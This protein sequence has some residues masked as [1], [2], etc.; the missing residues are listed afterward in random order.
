MAIDGVTMGPLP[1]SVEGYD[2]EVI[3][4]PHIYSAGE[5]VLTEARLMINGREFVYSQLV[6]PGEFS[7]DEF[8]EFM[9]DPDC[10]AR[11]WMAYA[12]RRERDWDYEN[13]RPGRTGDHWRK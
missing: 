8:S 4:K 13:M 10:R 3:V 2:V 6:K 7:E 9:S 1:L 11:R 5:G 12:I